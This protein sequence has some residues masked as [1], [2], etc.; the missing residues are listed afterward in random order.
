MHTCTHT[1]ADESDYKKPS[2]RRPVICM[3]IPVTSARLLYPTL[4]HPTHLLYV[5]MYMILI[6]PV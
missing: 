4:H 2:A 5:V 1:L 3:R 6:V